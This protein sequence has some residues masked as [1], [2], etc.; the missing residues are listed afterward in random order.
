LVSVTYQD[1][2]NLMNFSEADITPTL[3][4]NL[5]DYAI[6]AVNLEAVTSIATMVGVAGGKTLTLT[7][8]EYAVVMYAARMF[9]YSMFSDIQA[10]QVGEVGM[11]GADVITNP[12]T[13]R[14]FRRM[15]RRLQELDRP[16]EFLRT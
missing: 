7:D 16:R 1:F 3:T 5:I 6:R 9:Y 15:C 2:W 12:Q 8:E 4:E 14:T 13:M 10:A 11:G